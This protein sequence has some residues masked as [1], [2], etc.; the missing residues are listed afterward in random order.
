MGLN[1]TPYLP[2]PDY[3]STEYKKHWTGEYV[4]CK[5]PRGQTLD[6]SPEDL[7]HAWPQL[8]QNFPNI[9]VGSDLGID[10]NSCFDRESRYTPY[11]STA[12]NAPDWGSVRWGE[13]QNDCLSKN[14]GRYGEHQRKSMQLR[15]SRTMPK[16]DELTQH[17]ESTN[18]AKPHHRTA[19]LIRTWEG[20]VY[21]ENDLQAIRSLVTETSLLSGG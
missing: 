2:Y 9:S 18:A 17:A 13:L 12:K 10:L 14:K 6:K 20:Y 4:S 5:G 3:Q 11:D 7:V 16:E 21:T 15:P 1:A 19:I 8:P